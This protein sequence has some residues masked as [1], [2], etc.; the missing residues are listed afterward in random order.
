MLVELFRASEVW[1]AASGA[2]HHA[3]PISQLIFPFLNFLIFVYLIK[4]FVVPL[5]KGH[6]KSRREGL[7]SAVREADE[8]KKRAEAAVRDYRERLARLNQE[9]RQI[10]DSLK[11]D[12]EREKTKLLREAEDLA[13]K[14]KE[15]ARFL[16]EQEVKVARQKIREEMAGNARANAAELLRRNLSAADQERLVEEFVQG[17]GQVR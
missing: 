11:T 15:D 4:R 6:L 10:E 16:A 17:I 14:V 3:A 2:E 9:V 7:L 8:G 1:A 5:I 12:G 13:S